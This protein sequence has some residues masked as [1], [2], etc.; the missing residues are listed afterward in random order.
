MKFTLALPLFV[1]LI[2]LQVS[3]NSDTPWEAYVRTEKAYVWSEPGWTYQDCQPQDKKDKGPGAKTRFTRREEA[4]ETCKKRE[5]E[6]LLSESDSVEVLTSSAKDTKGISIQKPIYEDKRVFFSGNWEKIRYYKV[7]I[8]GKNGA[9]F[10]GW[11]S[12]EQVTRPEPK[13]FPQPVLAKTCKSCGLGNQSTTGLPEMKEEARVSRNSLEILQKVPDL[14]IKSDKELD[15]FA[16][17]H[18]GPVEENDLFKRLLPEIN[19]ATRQAEEAFGIPRAL[20]RCSMLAESGLK[21]GLTSE[22]GAKG[23]MQVMPSTMSFIERLAKDRSL[24]YGEMLAQMQKK[25]RRVQLNN[26]AVR[27]QDNISSAVAAAAFY[28]RFMFDTELK[29]V[30][31]K[32]SC[33][34][35][36]GDLG[37][38]TRK[39]LYLLAVGYNAGHGL[40]ARIAGKTPSEIRNTKEGPPPSESRE[41]VQRIEKCM[42]SGWET[43]FKESEAALNRIERQRET[44]IRT[45]KNQVAAKKKAYDTQMKAYQAGQERLKLRQQIVAD[46]DAGKKKGPKPGAITVPKQPVPPDTAK[47]EE[48]I[49][50]YTA[51]NAINANNSYSERVGS[52][53]K[54]LASTP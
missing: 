47:E 31:E 42:G 18:R 54:R 34:D 46:I 2:S 14:T 25:N 50:H 52:C 29:K 32:K 28:F 10:E 16:C 17:L 43:S 1:F 44:D 22:A 9:D 30:I 53:T 37:N 20:I 36:S 3:G 24:P 6:H 38:L 8:K 35:C 39:D 48:R 41:Y 11:M 4:L 40:I 5:K 15:R 27:E 45:L 7:R 23:Y 26:R 19:E 33:K 21:A 51:M 12:A 49:A 13:E